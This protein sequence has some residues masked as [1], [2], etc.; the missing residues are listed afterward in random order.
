MKFVCLGKQGAVREILTNEY[1][2]ARRF[3]EVRLGET[4]MYYRY[5]IK[6]RYISYEEVAH[7]YLR[8]ESGESGEF[9]LKEF[10][11][12]VK[13][14]DGSLHKLRMERAENAKAVLA[15]LEKGYKHIM[16]GFNRSDKL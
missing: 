5:F 6:V 12:M 1:K 3:G 8:E 16:I 9:L 2:S 11:L 14:Q 10:Y 7:A 4:R 13:A 15:D